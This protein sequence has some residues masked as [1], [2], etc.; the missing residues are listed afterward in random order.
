MY[1]LAPY[2]LLF[3]ESGGMRKTKKSSLYDIFESI[4]K[5]HIT[6]DTFY[7]IDG[8][9]LLHCVPWQP[10]QTFLSVCNSYISFVK[11]YYGSNVVIIFDGY[12]ESFKTQ[13]T[14][15]GDDVHKIA[16][17]LTLYLMIKQMSP[18]GNKHFCQM[19]IINAF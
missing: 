7:V 19:K 17:Q 14:T 11:K 2:P 16:E 9:Y 13:K 12:N 4:Q 8:G 6:F 5:D 3:D 10:N 1:E 15:R 18:L